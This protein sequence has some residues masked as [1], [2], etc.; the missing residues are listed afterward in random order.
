M[1]NKA[2]R[3]TRAA[4]ETT[5]ASRYRKRDRMIGSWEPIGSRLVRGQCMGGLRGAVGLLLY[6]CTA[7]RRRA[8][9]RAASGVHAVAIG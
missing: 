4:P 7:L 9:R 3:L 2:N 5:A 6:W 1:L 8:R